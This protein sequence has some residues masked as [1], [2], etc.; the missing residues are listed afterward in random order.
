MVTFKIETSWL[1]TDPPR[2]IWKYLLLKL[3]NRVRYFI[4]TDSSDRR[5]SFWNFSAAD[6]CPVTRGF[7]GATKLNKFLSKEVI[8]S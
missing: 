4:D 6:A 3:W 1:C 5:T 7:S 8:Q 2:Y